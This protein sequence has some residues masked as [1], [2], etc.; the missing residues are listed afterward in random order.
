[1][2]IESNPAGD[3]HI[4]E[5]FERHTRR[6][7]L[8]DPWEPIRPEVIKTALAPKVW[9]RRLVSL[10]R[11]LL[12]R[13]C[14]SSRG[15]NLSKEHVG[16]VET[17]RAVA[18]LGSQV[19]RQAPEVRRA[20]TRRIKEMIDLVARQSP[21]WGQRGA[22]ERALAAVATLVGALQL[23]RAVEDPRLCVRRR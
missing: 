6:S 11:G 1:M 22:H 7:G 15:P 17:G 4:P 21:D 2:N 18:A 23:A 13:R 10:R 16:V 19:P 12:T 8:T 14:G 9:R 5:G 20:A 3:A